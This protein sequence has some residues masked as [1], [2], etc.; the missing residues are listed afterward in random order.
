MPSLVDFLAQVV[1]P[2][3]LLEGQEALKDASVR[4]N[5]C[6][7]WLHNA[8]K[9]NLRQYPALSV[10]TQE[11]KFDLTIFSDDQPDV[12]VELR[13]FPT[14]YGRPGK[15]ITEHLGGVIRELEILRRTKPGGG[16]PLV[17]WVAYPV[18]VGELNWNEHVAKVVKASNKTIE[19]ARVGVGKEQQAIAYLS[20][21]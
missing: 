14:N 5:S 2:K 12:L 18:P 4:R 20:Y 6:E 3:V 11:G 7:R 1:I 15:P 16:V 9:E 17:L 19:V 21:A 13:T 8:L 10:A